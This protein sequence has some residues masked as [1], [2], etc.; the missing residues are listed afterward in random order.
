MVLL[1]HVTLEDQFI[2]VLYDQCVIWLGAAEG[3]PPF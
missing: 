1:C 3:Q 2:N